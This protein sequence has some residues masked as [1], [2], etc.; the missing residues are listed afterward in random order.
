MSERFDEE[1]EVETEDE[2]FD[3]TDDGKAEWCVEKIK[4]H[5]KEIE[6]WTAHYEAQ[7]RRECM[8]H[9]SAIIRF[10]GKLRTFLDQK[11]KEGVT[12]ET[13]T[14]PFV[15]DLPSGK[16]FIKRQNPE[17]DRDEGV[18]IEWLRKNAPQFIKTK[19]TVDWSGL[20]DS[21]SFENGKAFMVDDDGVINDVP[22]VTVTERE[23]IFD[24]EVKKDG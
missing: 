10:K 16:I 9:E 1:L 11:I 5:K 20:K 6:K 15:Y 22:G 12:R 7:K 14:M 21:V 23:D 4:E 3:V 2:G 24:M 8:K 13:K 17:Y 18:L 19:E